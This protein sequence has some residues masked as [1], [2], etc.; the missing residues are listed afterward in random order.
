MNKMQTSSLLLFQSCALITLVLFVNFTFYFC[1]TTNFVITIF[2]I[3]TTLH[4]RCWSLSIVLFRWGSFMQTVK[5]SPKPNETFASTLF[6]RVD[7][8][9]IETQFWGGYKMWTQRD[10]C[11]KRNHQKRNLI[12]STRNFKIL[13]DSMC[14]FRER[15]AK[16][17]QSE[18]RHLRNVILIFS[19]SVFVK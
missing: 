1:Q 9:Q 5:S 15:L 3:I 12:H 16:L 6:C 7:R 8:F 18:G 11:W 10:C 2:A 17:T 19:M 14:N 13:Q 4:P